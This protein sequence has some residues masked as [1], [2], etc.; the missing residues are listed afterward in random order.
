MI[1]LFKQ[2]N[3][4]S[5]KNKGFTLVETLIAILVFSLT[6]TVIFG[7]LSNGISNLDFSKRK[8]LAQ[9]LAQE[10]IEYVRNFRDTEVLFFVPSDP[11]SGW[12]DFIE[13]THD[14]SLNNGGC[15]IDNSGIDF[16]NIHMPIAQITFPLCGGD[17]MNCT[18]L[19]YH[20]STGKYDYRD[21]GED[22]GFVRRIRFVLD[23][24]KQEVKVTSTVSWLQNG[25]MRT[26]FSEEGLY[27]WI[28][29]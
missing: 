19:L 28:E 27:N 22:S 21:G 24:S 15:Y 17:G 12:Q 18:H 1:Y 6:L 14:C 10:G 2:K 11:Q 4:Y 25:T 26:A 5:K 8:I 13:K 23:S 16:L 9:Y 29:Q 20:S 3:I 7:V